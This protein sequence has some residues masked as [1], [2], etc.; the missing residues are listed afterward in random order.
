MLR[1]LLALILAL[2]SVPMSA[3]AC[4][5]AVSDAAVMAGMSLDHAHHAPA[6]APMPRHDCIGCVSVADW[7]GARV[8]PPAIIAA[9]ALTSR[10]AVLPL[11]PGEAPVPPPPRAT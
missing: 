1:L 6:K 3:M 9:P 7:S 2:A 5:T 11:L 10:I 4:E 8:T